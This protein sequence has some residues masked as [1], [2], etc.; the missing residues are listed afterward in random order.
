[1]CTSYFMCSLSPAEFCTSALVINIYILSVY[2]AAM[3]YDHKS[4]SSRHPIRVTCKSRMKVRIRVV[5]R[6]S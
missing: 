3:P 5:C 2:L 6:L 4:N 1:V